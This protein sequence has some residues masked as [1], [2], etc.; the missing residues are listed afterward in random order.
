MPALTYETSGT[1]ARVTLT[2]PEV[3]NA[4]DDALIGELT[5]A[6]ERAAAADTIET[7]ILAAEG[8]SFS[9]GADLNWMRRMAGYGEAENLADARALGRLLQAIDGCPKT[10]IA[11][12]QGAA[13][14]GGV[15]LV[16]ACDIAVASGRASFC[17]SEVKLGIVPAVISPFVV[18]AIG[19]RAA[20]RYFQTAERFDAATAHRLGLVSELAEDE[21]AMDQAIEAILAALADGGPLAKRAAKD[22]VFLAESGPPESVIDE[23]CRRIANIRAGVEGQEGLGAFLAKRTPSWR[24]RKA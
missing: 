10:T 22:L 13:F 2:R 6:F 12:V 20:R 14:G 24:Q 11:R 21:A 5:G 18:R 1:V 15:G 3:H 19:P 7:V 16:A 17:L 8:R 23:T 4:F 9:A